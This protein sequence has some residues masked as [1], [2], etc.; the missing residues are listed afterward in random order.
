MPILIHSQCNC[1]IAV[2]DA[3]FKAS[4]SSKGS[5]WKKIFSL[6]RNNVHEEESF[7]LI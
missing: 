4:N 7:I 1:T 6:I 2:C 5:I 3:T